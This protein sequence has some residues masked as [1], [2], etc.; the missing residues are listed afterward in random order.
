MDP[1]EAPRFQSNTEARAA[2]TGHAL[3]GLQLNAPLLEPTISGGGG[4]G[5]EGVE[6]SP[7]PSTAAAAADDGATKKATR[8]GPAPS[9]LAGLLATHSSDSALCV[10]TLPKKRDDQAAGAWLKATEE[11]VA[12][13]QRVIFVQESGHERIQFMRD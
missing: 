3:A 5:G 6:L 8:K 11:L 9:A 7:N 2:P 4:A 13:L 1:E 10:I 12:A